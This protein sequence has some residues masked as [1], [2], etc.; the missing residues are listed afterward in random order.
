[1]GDKMNNRRLLQALLATNLLAFLERAFCD[2]DPRNQL[3]TP[4]YLE[5]LA[6][7]L[8]DVATGASRRLIINLPPR[9][10]KSILVSV[11]LPAWLLGRDPRLRIAVVSHGQGL[12]RDLALKSRRLVD[13]DW[14]RSVFPQM[15][16]SAD[17]AGA[18]DFETTQGGGRY[19]ASVNTG[20]TGRG[21]DVIIVDDP[22]SAQD[23]RSAV[24]RERVI[25]TYETMIVSR[26]DDP[27]R[28]IICVVH[29]RMHE[30]DLTGHLMTQG[31]WRQ[32]CL[33]L[34]AEEEMTYQ[35]GSRVWTRRMNEP[36]I[37]DLYPHDVI[38]KIRAERGEAIF[39]TQ[40]Q[41]NPTASIGELLRPEHI[42][43]FGDL[44]PDARRITISIDT[45]TK[46]TPSA[47]YTV[48]LVIASDSRRHY[49]VDVLRQRID[50]VEARDAAMRL[51]QEYRPNTILI[52]DASSGPGLAQMLLERGHRSEL[53]PTRG[54]GKEERFEPH[55]HFFVEGRILVKTDQ[56]WT[57]D[58]VNEWLRFPF[59]RHDDQ[60]DAMSQYLEWLSTNRLVNPVLRGAGGA[61]ARA[62]RMLWN[63]PRLRKGEH[64]MRPW[65]GGR[66]LPLSRRPR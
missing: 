64:P 25:E 49:I 55:L 51:I 47:S 43:Y 2:L 65:S 11:V 29:Q 38:Q 42:R 45:A 12:A 63:G 56:P 39:A 21:F 13:F 7:E 31:G 52:E 54:R 10:L 61:E 33:P 8:L 14:Y 26:L 62:A 48:F 5:L 15:R 44:P 30:R 35:I 60:V 36:L 6:E 50:P 53:R 23:A 17:R 9:H 41:Q 4:P 3:L 27:L 19:A 24:E 40:Y 58:L 22:L 1:M 59:S 16:L 32:I 57:T 18:M 66:Q 34:V 37:P 20:I 46:T 28:G